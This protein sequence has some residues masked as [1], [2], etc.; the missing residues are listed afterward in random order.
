MNDDFVLTRLS[1]LETRL[2]LTRGDVR[3]RR[4][5]HES[6]AVLVIPR[7]GPLRAPLLMVMTR[8]SARTAP[9]S[10]ADTH[11]V[12][13]F[14][15]FGDRYRREVAD[16]LVGRATRPS[17]APEARLRRVLDHYPG[18]ALAVGTESGGCRAALRD[19]RTVLCS[20]TLEPLESWPAIFG[21]FLYGWL[22]D[23]LELEALTD[24]VVI[25]GALSDDGP[26][27]GLEVAGRVE[28][29]LSPGAAVKGVA[30]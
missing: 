26:A 23:E 13:R 22:S 8:W 21:S 24:A 18:C 28:I 17:C 11:V 7:S 14:D 6:M 9:H 30:S 1:M 4:S 10:G 25:F 3:P 15:D 5:A 29:T 27:T 2:H 12:A 19:G 20:G 16:V